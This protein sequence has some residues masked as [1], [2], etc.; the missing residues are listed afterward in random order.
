MTPAEGKRQR[1][2]LMKS[3]AREER[4]KQ[5]GRLRELKGAIRD[6]R[7]QRRLAMREAR[8]ACRRGRLE[9]RERVREMRRRA[10][11]ELAAAVAAE[12]QA[13]KAECAAGLSYAKDRGDKHARARHELATE[14]AFR[15]E[16]RRIERGNK[17]RR[18]EL[19]RPLAR[20]RAAAERRGES[21]DE[22]R[23][24]IP[25]ELAALF[26]RVKAGI[27]GTDRET[28]TEAFLRYAEENPGEVLESIEH[29]SDA[30]LRALE[31]E[32][33][34]LARARAAARGPARARARRPPAPAQLAEAP[35]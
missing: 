15:A 22:V 32:H 20:G 16:M 6:A 29:E 8:Q 10:L 26:E 2:A 21:D 12:R 13:A 4:K 11:A 9:A 18:K 31:H 28:R 35:F 33:Q 14:R 34:E 1:A 30:R 23:G 3:I 25:P 24:N 5:S 17:E 27:R 19:A 7:G